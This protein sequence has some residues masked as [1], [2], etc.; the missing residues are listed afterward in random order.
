MPRFFGTRVSRCI[1]EDIFSS[2]HWSYHFHFH[3]HFDCRSWAPDPTADQAGDNMH[4]TMCQC[5]VFLKLLLVISLQSLC[6]SSLLISG[7]RS[8]PLIKMWETFTFLQ[9][10]NVANLFFLPPNVEVHQQRLSKIVSLR[11]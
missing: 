4:L 6:L 7:S 11:F 8:R 2:F 10:S 5:K 1:G 9:S 3:I